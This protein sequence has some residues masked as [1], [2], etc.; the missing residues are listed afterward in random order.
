MA[1]KKHDPKDMIQCPLCPDYKGM[2]LITHFKQVHGTNALGIDKKL[3]LPPGTTL[4]CSPALN[5]TFKSA[6]AKGAT[7]LA[8]KNSMNPKVA[9]KSAKEI[10]N[11]ILDSGDFEDEDIT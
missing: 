2:S 4:K 8:L 5:N 7:A 9:K 1:K 6:G 11:E 3:G 10:E